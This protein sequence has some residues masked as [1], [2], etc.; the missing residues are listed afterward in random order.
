[1]SSDRTARTRLRGTAVTDLAPANQRLGDSEPFA[2][3][4]PQRPPLS[5]AMPSDGVIDWRTHIGAVLN[6]LKTM[7]RIVERWGDNPERLSPRLALEMRWR[8]AGSR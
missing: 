3:R 2:T 6:G 7:Q 8:C 5:D 4:S 1:M